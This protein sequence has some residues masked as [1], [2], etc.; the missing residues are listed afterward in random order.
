M[1]KTPYTNF[2]SEQVI[3]HPFEQNQLIS[4]NMSYCV[5]SMYSEAT[6]CPHATRTYYEK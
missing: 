6:C 3:K 5:H 1:V 2:S 4:E